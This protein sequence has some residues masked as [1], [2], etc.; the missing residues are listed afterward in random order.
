MKCIAVRLK[1]LE[2]DFDPVKCRLRCH[3]HII[4]LVVKAFL[5]GNDPETFEAVV[6]SLVN[7]DD[8]EAELLLW[9]KK[10]PLGKLHNIIIWIGRSPQR[11]DKYEEKVNQ[12]DPECTATSL[13]HGNE[14]RWGSNY[15]ELVPAIQQRE[16]L[17]EFVSTAICH[18]LHG[19]GD[20]L[21]TALKHDELTPED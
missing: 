20:S 1:L 10:G 18:N 5:W 4:N 8:E 13:V 17:E 12:L 14:T 15:D 6:D 16:A 19:E 7:K 3:G 2:I 21:G 11:R 9:R